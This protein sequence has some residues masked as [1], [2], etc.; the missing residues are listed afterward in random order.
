M[1]D[2]ERRVVII[3][4]L[5]SEMRTTRIAQKYLNTFGIAEE[6]MGKNPNRG[7]YP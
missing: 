6:I 4:K 7:V 3:T 2:C 1:K 5:R